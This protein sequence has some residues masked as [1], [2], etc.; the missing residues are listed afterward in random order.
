MI[1]GSDCE[2]AEKILNKAGRYC[3]KVDDSGIELKKKHYQKMM[4]QLPEYQVDKRIL[5]ET[6]GDP[7]GY[8]LKQ[9]GEDHPCFLELSRNAPSPILTVKDIHELLEK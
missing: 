9:L 1:G 3:M 7:L 6:D 5:F 8:R 2:I 4:E